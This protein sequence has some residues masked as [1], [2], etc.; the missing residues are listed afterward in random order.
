MGSRS[1]RTHRDSPLQ[2]RAA[3]R[4]PKSETTG[5]VS[6][7]LAR[8]KHRPKLARSLRLFKSR[9]PDDRFGD[10]GGARRPDSWYGA[11]VSGRRGLHM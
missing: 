1:G 9:E 2:L 11:S 5:H 3:R 7:R 6:K 10:I 8:P 4:D